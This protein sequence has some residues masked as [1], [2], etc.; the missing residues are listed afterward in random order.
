MKQD[1]WNKINSGKT[2]FIKFPLLAL[3]KCYTKT[4]HPLLIDRKLNKIYIKKF[5]QWT[6][7]EMLFIIGS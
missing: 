5:R 7:Q 3:M 4:A 6:T 2:K 1:M